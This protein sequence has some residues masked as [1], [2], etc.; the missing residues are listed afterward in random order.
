MEDAHTLW[1]DALE[2]ILI[3]KNFE[4]RYRAASSAQGENLALYAEIIRID[5]EVKLERTVVEMDAYPL[6]FEPVRELWTKDERAKLRQTEVKSQQANAVVWARAKKR[7]WT[8]RQA[9]PRQSTK[10]EEIQAFFVDSA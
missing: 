7:R 2:I 6:I 5:Y 4:Y 9:V 3:R 10:R 1:H 8:S